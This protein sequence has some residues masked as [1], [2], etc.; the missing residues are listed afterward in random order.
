MEK[1]REQKKQNVEQSNE[2]E[3]PTE[4]ELELYYDTELELYYDTER[5]SW[6]DEAVRLQRLK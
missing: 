2:I 1:T 5:E 6:R 3:D 4:R